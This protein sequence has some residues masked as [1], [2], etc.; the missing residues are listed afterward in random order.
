MQ[1]APCPR[2]RWPR[3]SRRSR[4]QGR[5]RRSRWAP[6]Q[7]PPPRSWAT[8]AAWLPRRKDVRYGTWR[9][10]MAEPMHKDGVCLACGGM[11]DAQGY[12]QGGEV[13]PDVAP[14]APDEVGDESGQM[15]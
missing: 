2:A 3:T 9:T 8:R 11:V 7:T 12:S 1:T 6:R 5:S 13:K 10:R 15:K 4:T 14:E